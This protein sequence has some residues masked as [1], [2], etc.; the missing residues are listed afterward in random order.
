MLTQLK[1]L[2]IT[3]YFLRTERLNNDAQ[4]KNQLLHE[5]IWKPWDARSSCRFGPF[6]TPPRGVDGTPL[7]SKSQ[8][9]LCKMEKID[10]ML[11]L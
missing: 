4:S 3:A 11:V 6:G 8:I 2:E 1:I 7:C 10:I 9:L 5:G